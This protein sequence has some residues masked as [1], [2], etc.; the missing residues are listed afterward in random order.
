MAQHPY[1]QAKPIGVLLA[2]LFVSL[3]TQTHNVRAFQ[4]LVSPPENLLPLLS[5]R[6]ESEPR[7]GHH[8]ERT[9]TYAENQGMWD[10]FATQ[11]TKGLTS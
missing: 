6:R 1:K 7:E 5:C 4:D 2:R 9:G 10:N 3:Y 11:C 8:H